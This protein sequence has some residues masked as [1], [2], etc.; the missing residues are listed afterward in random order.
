[1]RVVFAILLILPGLGAEEAWP[2]LR[3]ERT[4]ERGRLRIRVENRGGGPA[5]S[6]LVTLRREPGKAVRIDLG[7]VAPGK[8]A[9]GE[10]A[11]E[12]PAIRA[13]AADR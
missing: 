2:K 12:R 4:W 10:I 6:I 9:Q 1:M 8:T 7:T 13:L 3:L 5:S 11:L